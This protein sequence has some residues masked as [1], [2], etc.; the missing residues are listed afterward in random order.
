MNLSEAIDGYVSRRRIEGAS[1]VNGECVLRS[2]CRT[3]GDVPLQTM[4]ADAVVGFINHPRKAAITRRGH[5]SLVNRFLQFWAFRDAMPVLILQRPVKSKLCFVPHIY[6]HA[7]VRI[8]VAATARSQRDSQFLDPNT[9]RIFI[10]T[11]YATGAL[12]NEVLQ[13]TL[14]AFDVRRHHISLSGD[15]RT[16]RRSVPICSDLWMS[17][18]TFAKNQQKVVGCDARIFRTVSGLPIRPGYLSAC[19][20]RLRRIAGVIRRDDTKRPPR[21]QDFRATF[22]VHRLALWV[23]QDADMNR[24]LPSL[25]AYMGYTGLAAAEKYLCHVPERFAADLSKLSDKSRRKHWRDD[26]QLMSFLASL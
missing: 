24:V 25:S 18:Y 3:L 6:S 2:L 10:L 1:Y 9:L 4:T 19:F 5:F 11:L 23:H 16:R 20:R 8:L 15:L 12:V 14:S 22:A 7:Q 26:P 13:L 17:L 21:M